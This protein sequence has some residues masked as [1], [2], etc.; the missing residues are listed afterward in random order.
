MI[1]LLKASLREMPVL[2]ELAA[3]VAACSACAEYG[4]TR[5]HVEVGFLLDGIDLKGTGPGVDEGVVT[6]IDVNLV[7]TKPTISF[8]DNAATEANLTLYPVPI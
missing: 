7:A 4:G 1:K 3:V 8:C 5:P 2:T 6:A